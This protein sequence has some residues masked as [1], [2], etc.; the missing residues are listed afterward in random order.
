MCGVWAE[1]VRWSGEG[2][3]ERGK[4]SN[5]K[6]GGAVYRIV[7]GEMRGRGRGGC[8]VGRGRGGG[9]IEDVSMS[10]VEG[11]LGTDCTSDG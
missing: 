5:V 9:I 2:R 7:R 11:H 6:W 8:D 1:I 10:C 4:E 3:G